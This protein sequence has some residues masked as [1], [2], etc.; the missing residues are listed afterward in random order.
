M[1][2]RV[3]LSCILALSFFLRSRRPPRATR[4]DTLCPYTTLFRSQTH[5]LALDFGGI[6]GHEPSAAQFGL[7]GVIVFDQRTGNAQT[8]GACLAGGTT[9][10]DRK[11]TV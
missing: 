11:S 6:T 4:T 5:F 9:A 1:L 8:D 3:W 10:G 7:Q 2:L